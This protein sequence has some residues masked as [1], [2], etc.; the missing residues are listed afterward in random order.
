MRLRPATR[1]STLYAA[2]VIAVPFGEYR[3]TTADRMIKRMAIP[4]LSGFL[5]KCSLQTNVRRSVWS[6]AVDNQF[7]TPN[8]LCID[9]Q[10]RPWDWFR[11]C[12]HCSSF[13]HILISSRDNTPILVIVLV[14][15]LDEVIEEF[16]IFFT[17]VLNRMQG[18]RKIPS[19]G[20]HASSQHCKNRQVADKSAN[21]RYEE[22]FLP[23]FHHRFSSST[24]T[25]DEY[26]P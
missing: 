1:N 11:A 26:S 15:L 20:D 6:T 2:G 24:V 22:K 8:D 25:N 4:K 13:A 3:R 18:S 10:L 16:A 7:S 5:R 19:L 17:Y 23:R 9:H 14:L 21:H 12:D